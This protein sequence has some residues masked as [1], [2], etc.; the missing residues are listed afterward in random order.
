MINV[1]T[2]DVSPANGSTEIWPGTH[3]DVSVGAGDDIKIDP[4]TVESA[5]RGGAADP[6]DVQSRS[7]LIRDIRLWHA[8]MPN[9]TDEP[10]PMIAMIHTCGWLET[11]KPLKFP[12]RYRGLLR[13]SG[14]HPGRAYVD[15]PIDHIHAP[16]GFQYEPDPA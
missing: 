15:E 9:R 14:P 7:A 10:R 13:P 11:G 4:E 5:P 16:H 8:G 3:R 12:T 1:L 2:V 6:A